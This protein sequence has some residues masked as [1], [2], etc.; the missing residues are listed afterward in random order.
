MNPL[1]YFPKHPLVYSL[2]GLIFTFAIGQLHC[3]D[4]Y[5]SEGTVGSFRVTFVGA[6]ALGSASTPL[7]FSRE[8]LNFRINIEALRKDDP[9]QKDVT[10]NQPVAIGIE[11]SGKLEEEAL[12]A[13]LTQGMVENVEV[14]F[15]H[16]FG[17]VR[18]I[19]RDIGYQPAQV[20]S[21]AKCQNG[22]DDD[23]DGLIDLI[24]PDRFGENKTTDRG[25]YYGND[26]SEESGSGAIGVSPPIFF[27]NPRIGDVQSLGKNKDESLLKEERVTIDQGWMVVT[28]ISVDGMYVTDFEG[29]RWDS[30]TQLFLADQNDTLFYRSIFAFSFNTP[31]N[32]Q[33]GECLVQLD[34]N[35]E[36]F[37]GYTE[38]GKPTWKKGDYDYC[39]AKARAAGLTGCDANEAS[40][41][42]D[43]IRRCFSYV[44]NLAN[45]PIDIT[46]ILLKEAGSTDEISGWDQRVYATERFESALVQVSNAELFHELSACDRNGNKTIDFSDDA[47]KTCHND[48]SEDVYCA[49]KESYDQYNQWTVSFEDGL[50]E[51]RELAVVSAGSIPDFDAKKA[52]EKAQ[53][54]QKPFIISKLVGTLRHLA[55]SRPPWILEVRRP[56]DCPECKN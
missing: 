44:Q 32:I 39:M 2:C 4:P 6:P 18:I 47:E 35:I 54:E 31:K 51:R 50:G 21:Q 5:E 53:Q 34:G 1:N 7:S 20:A 37:F 28:R 17:P 9:N 40:S 3:S 8:A 13:S 29:V 56:S 30:A 26:D 23:Q 15:R 25:C 55:F 24:F 45:T 48:C 43:D 22:I 19:V 38:V 16:A 49:V 36:E 41:T 33:E 11:P 10:F 14:S 27:K 52:F 12:S 46:K 42:T